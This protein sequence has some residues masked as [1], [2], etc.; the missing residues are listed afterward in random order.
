M[1]LESRAETAE[2]TRKVVHSGGL[3]ATRGNVRT[4]RHVGGSKGW[5]WLQGKGGRITLFGRSDC[6]Q[7]S[8]K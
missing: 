3:E 8:L 4:A 6:V 2:V 7:L 5:L 1:W